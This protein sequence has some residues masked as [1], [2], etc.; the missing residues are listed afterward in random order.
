MEYLGVINSM[1]QKKTEHSK[2]HAQS[3]VVMLVVQTGG[4]LGLYSWILRVKSLFYRH[5]K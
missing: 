3:L 1:K 4:E 5:T 2:G